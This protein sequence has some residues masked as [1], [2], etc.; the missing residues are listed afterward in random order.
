MRPV[1]S[2]PRGFTLI[3]LLVV[4]VII[5]IATAF[6]MPRLGSTLF[7]DQLKATSRHLIG[8]VS[9]ASQEAVRK[10]SVILLRI[11]MEHNR[12]W[13]VEAAGER[14]AGEENGGNDG[15]HGQRLS[16]PGSVRIVD[17]SSLYGGKRS[18][19]ITDISFSKMGYVDKTFIHLHDND[20]RSMT[21]ML[22]PFI[23]TIRVADSYVGLS[24]EKTPF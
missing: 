10:Q 23:G 21:I 7:S 19:G 16:V 11:D 2:A 18:R 22:S 5:G 3:E 24:D 12:V 13:L 20:G 4:M 6:V 17:V 15:R 1:S 9:E 14:K 8:L